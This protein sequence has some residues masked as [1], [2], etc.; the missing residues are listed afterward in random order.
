MTHT[1]LQNMLSRRSLRLALTFALVSVVGWALLTDN[2]ILSRKAEAAGFVV[3]NTS[4]SGAGSLRQAILNANAN[5]AGV[6][7]TITFNIAGQRTSGN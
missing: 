1:K 4:D 6:V 2:S 7:D 3:T 5:G